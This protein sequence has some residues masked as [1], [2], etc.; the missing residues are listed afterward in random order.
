MSGFVPT[1]SWAGKQYERTPITRVRIRTLI[2]VRQAYLAY[3]NLN[4]YRRSSREDNR[5]GYKFAVSA[6]HLDL[7]AMGNKQYAYL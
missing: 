3:K 7:V 5:S 4:A 2:R 1:S 6:L